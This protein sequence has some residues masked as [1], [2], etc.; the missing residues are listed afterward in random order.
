MDVDALVAEKHLQR[1][2]PDLGLILRQKVD[3]ARIR[4]EHALAQWAETKAKILW[5]NA[6][7]FYGDAVSFV[8]V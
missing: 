5:D 6:K 3:V 4:M 7:Q 2:S 1:I 8:N